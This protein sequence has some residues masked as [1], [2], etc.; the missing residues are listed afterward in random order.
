MEEIAPLSYMFLQKGTDDGKL[1]RAEMSILVKYHFEQVAE[2]CYLR[3]RGYG[4]L[5]ENLAKWRVKWMADHS[6]AQ[7]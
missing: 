1:T 7:E 3:F 4:N 2:Y 6:K 5:Q